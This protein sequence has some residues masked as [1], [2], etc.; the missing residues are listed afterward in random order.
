MDMKA[1]VY[2]LNGTAGETASFSK[3]FKAAVRK[4]LIQRAF[5]AER[6]FLRQA[7]GRDPLAGHRSSA[8]YHGMRH[9]RY[10]MMNRE[11]ARM[12]RIHN[13]GYLSYTARVVPQAVKGRR[14]HP[15]KAEKVWEVKI[16]K[17]E[18]EKAIMSA[19]AATIYKDMLTSRGHRIEEIKSVP[20]VL[21]DKVQELKK[22][23]EVRELLKAL[24]FS[25][26]LER[27]K[28]KKVRAG[29]GTMRGRKY[30]RKTG[31]LMVV[32]ED[33]GIVKASRNIAG[34]DTITLDQL[35]IMMLAPGG[36][37]G[38]LTLWSKSAL[39]EIEK[40]A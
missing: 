39:E 4:D 12:K 38:R 18:R 23:K 27:T 21:E 22:V 35:N 31:P 7:Y 6:S 28:E 30:T 26:E 5:N 9:Y 17:K 16:N 1:T 2:K 36:A 29:K 33:K 40:K 3:A 11:M 13:Q 14:A 10:T 20:I 34:M 19:I 37:P 24:G 15:P 32:K 25:K 8:H